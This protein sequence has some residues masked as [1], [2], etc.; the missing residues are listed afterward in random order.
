MPEITRNNVDMAAQRQVLFI[1]SS[2]AFLEQLEKINLSI[3]D[4]VYFLLDKDSI[5]VSTVE[6]L[7]WCLYMEGD[8][9][10]YSYHRG[11]I[12]RL[13][14]CLKSLHDTPTIFYFTQNDITISQITF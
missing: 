4:T 14:N 1:A 5:Q 7:F 6:L 9:G 12:R 3:L 8:F 2:T 13:I 11:K 10:R